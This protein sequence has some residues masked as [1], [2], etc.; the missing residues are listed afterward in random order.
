MAMGSRAKEVNASCGVVSEIT[1]SLK[2]RYKSPIRA[3]DDWP[4]EASACLAL[5]KF[6]VAS[7]L[8]RTRDG[9]AFRARIRLTEL[10][11]QSI[12]DPTSGVVETTPLSDIAC[13]DICRSGGEYN[14]LDGEP[15]FGGH[16]T[17]HLYLT[18]FINVYTGISEVV[19]GDDA[20]AVGRSWPVAAR[21]ILP[22]VRSLQLLGDYWRLL[23]ELA[24]SC[25]VP[26]IDSRAI[27]GGLVR[28]YN[29]ELETYNFRLIVDGLGAEAYLSSSSGRAIF[30]HEDSETERQVYGRQLK[31]S[32][33]IAVQNAKQIQPDELRGIM[34]RIRNIG[35]GYMT[36]IAR[37]PSERRSRAGGWLGEILVHEGLDDAL[38]IDLTPSINSTPNTGYSGVCS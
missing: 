30:E 19:Q 29:A 31:F 33:Y 2:C 12:D 22:K 32:G 24:V 38:N 34:V 6:V 37:F 26:Y 9:E 28:D 21:E 35:V 20:R 15:E 23:F 5:P 16:G 36:Y 7:S 17:P 27:P 11:R 3:T 18:I 14:L 8:S 1:K 10:M 25:P 13:A 4:L